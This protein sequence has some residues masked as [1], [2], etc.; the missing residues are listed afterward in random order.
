[1]QKLLEPFDIDN[2]FI[3]VARDRKMVILTDDPDDPFIIRSTTKHNVTNYL[4]IPDIYIDLMQDLDMEFANNIMVEI[5]DTSLRQN[6][7]NNMGWHSD[8]AIDLD[9]MYDIAIAGFPSACNGL[10]FP[11]ACNGLGFP[12]ACNG[13]GFPSSESACGVL[14]IKHKSNL[15]A[16]EYKTIDLT[17]NIVK[18]SYQENLDHVHRIRSQSNERW[19]CLTF[20]KS[21]KKLSELRHVINKSEE[22]EFIRHKADE[23]KTLGGIN[24]PQL[25]YF[26]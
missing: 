7:I 3:Q 18:L 17:N 6:Q 2:D 9:P 15:F 16:P 13:L 26:I 8:C 5:Y 14:D 25:P 20:R 22:R 1:M 4:G 11:S 10:G 19:L 12:S 24:W 23:N 21:T